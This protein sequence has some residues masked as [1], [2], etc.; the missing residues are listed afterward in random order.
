M[1]I[2]KNTLQSFI[3]GDVIGVPYEFFNRQYFIEN[4]ITIN[5][6]LN[7][8]KLRWSD[9]TSMTLAT[10]DF[11][12]EHKNADFSK[13]NNFHPLMKNFCN[14]WRKGQYT[15]NGCF[16]IG[17]QTKEVLSY[18]I[19]GVDLEKCARSNEM[20][21]GNGA[22][23]RMLPVIKVIK[24]KTNL[25]KWEII[26]NFTLL[27]HNHLRCFIANYIYLRFIELKKDDNCFLNLKLIFNELNNLI[28]EIEKDQ[29]R[30]KQEKEW[31]V[32][33]LNSI[34]EENAFTN[35]EK[36][37]KKELKHFDRIFDCFNEEENILTKD[38]IK[39]SGY[40]IDTLEAVFWLYKN[41]LKHKDYDLTMIEAIELGGDVDTIC[42]LTGSLLDFNDESKINYISN[43]LDGNNQLKIVDNFF[44]NEMKNSEF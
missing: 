40:V 29:E 1:N 42:A 7:N 34:F 28:Q 19:N 38:E 3:F 44:E 18:Y 33:D 21:N 2:N 25:E 11:I 37:F 6:Y 27:T 4:K 26:K 8:E 15:I 14:F 32:L 12:N 5:N 23:M 9:D 43:M 24:D 41:Y 35:F 16:D 36:M 17:I 20:A 10:I 31:I 22:L 13:L 39:S 30:K